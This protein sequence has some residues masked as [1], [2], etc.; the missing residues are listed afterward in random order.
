MPKGHAA[1]RRKAQR[2]AHRAERKLRHVIKSKHH[3][4][5]DIAKAQAK[6]RRKRKKLAKLTIQE[7]II[8]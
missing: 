2:E 5:L 3:D 1:K 4:Q 6:L 7:C 8:L